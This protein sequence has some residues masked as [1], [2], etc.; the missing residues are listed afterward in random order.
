MEAKQMQAA[1]SKRKRPGPR[2][3]VP[4]WSP[5]PGYQRDD[6]RRPQSCPQSQRGSQASPVSGHS[7]PASLLTR[8]SSGLFATNGP[9]FSGLLPYPTPQIR[10]FPVLK[11]SPKSPIDTR[12]FS[13]YNPGARFDLL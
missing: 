12:P 10:N 11:N 1:N 5:Q 9:L 6:L 13:L 7:R 2:R 8:P 4:V 3:L